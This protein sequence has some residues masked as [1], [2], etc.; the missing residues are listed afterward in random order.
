MLESNQTLGLINILKVICKTTYTYAKITST[1]IT[2]FIL[3]FD[4]YQTS[5]IF[6]S[7]ENVIH[8]NIM[9][10]YMFMLGIMY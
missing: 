1:N 5:Q 8:L 7:N 10:K 3:F 9:S 2:H 6:F 4:R